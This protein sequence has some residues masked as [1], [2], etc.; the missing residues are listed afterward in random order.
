L[1]VYSAGVKQV[2]R[3]TLTVADG[4]VTLIN[5]P[6]VVKYISS[7]P[8]SFRTI[9]SLYPPGNKGDS[10]ALIVYDGTNIIMKIVGSG[11]A[12]YLCS[13]HSILIPANGL[14]INDYLAVECED[15]DTSSPGSSTQ[16][17]QANISVVYQ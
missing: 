5:H 12:N 14:R 16:K 2:F 9:N 13:N 8:V 17:K 3:D 6:C 1:S 7:S 10:V 15:F 4:K 11:I